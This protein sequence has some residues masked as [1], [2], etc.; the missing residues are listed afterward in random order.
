MLTCQ[1]IPSHRQPINHYHLSCASKAIKVVISNDSI[2]KNKITR[3]GVIITFAF[4]LNSTLARYIRHTLHVPNPN[5][6]SPMFNFLRVNRSTLRCI[7]F[8]SD[9]YVLHIDF[10]FSISLPMFN[11]FLRFIYADFFLFVRSFAFHL[12]APCLK[13]I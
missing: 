8:G 4:N 7:E 3:N 6:I 5:A 2:L 9:I 12:L 1:S 13:S 10:F 11:H